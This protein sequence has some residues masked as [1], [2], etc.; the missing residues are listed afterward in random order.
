MHKLFE[1]L[2]SQGFVSE[3]DIAKVDRLRKGKLV[4]LYESLYSTVFAAQY[5]AYGSGRDDPSDVDPFSYMASASMRADSGCLEPRCRLRKLDFLARFAAMYAN[6]VIVPLPL[7]HPDKVRGMDN[8]R[9]EMYQAVTSLF[10]LRP[11][12]EVGIVKPVTMRT[13]H[14]EH[15]RPFVQEMQV[16]VHEIAEL[17]AK[18][19]EDAFRMEYQLPEKSPTG[20]STVYI[21][22]PEEF[23]EHGS[24]VVTFDASD[25]WKAKSWK[26]NSD[27]R[28]LLKGRKKLYFVREV[29]NT[30]ADDTTFYL[31]YGQQGRSRLLTDKQGDALLLELLNQ[32][33]ELQSTSAALELL[34]HS[35]PILAEIPLATLIRIRREERDSFEAYRRAL[36]SLTAGVL[37]ETGSLTTEA[38]RD[39]FKTQLEPEIEKI[40]AEVRAERRRQEMRFSTGLSSVA[41][42]LLIGA[43]GGLPILI[44]GAFATAATAVGTKLL[45]KAAE[46]ACEHGEDI[47]QKNDLYFLARLIE[48]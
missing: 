20:R 28:T 44:K 42:A 36:T 40:Q 30:I 23:L 5:P 22:G 1:I 6:H 2:E 26:F 24:L 39:A 46:S 48:G 35:V 3:N 4:S 17:G 25:S 15:V 34:G 32:D 31:A 29:F 18:E 12:I 37:A 11:L 13:T 45:S 14:C 47:R 9:E 19:F 8:C 33:E 38:A 43:C 27:G 21:E 10:A 41:A 16:F 7:E